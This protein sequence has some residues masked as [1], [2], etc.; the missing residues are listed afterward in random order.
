MMPLKRA[1]TV[2]GGS[3]PSGRFSGATVEGVTPR[4]CRRNRG[5]ARP[6]DHD[7]RLAAGGYRIF[8]KLYS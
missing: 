6:L 4:S 3:W 2:K 5:H 8:G 7:P 1:I